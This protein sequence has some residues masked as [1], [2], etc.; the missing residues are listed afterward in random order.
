MIAP[1]PRPVIQTGTPLDAWIGGMPENSLVQVRGPVAVGKSTFLLALAMGLHTTNPELNVLT[2]VQPQDTHLVGPRSW[3]LQAT[4]V[5]DVAKAL[6]A[7]PN[8]DVVLIDEATSYSSKS[9][10][11]AATSKMWTHLIPRERQRRKLTV[12]AGTVRRLASTSSISATRFVGKAADFAADLIIDLA[13][14]A[15]THSHPGMVVEASIHKSRTSSP[16]QLGKRLLWLRPK[17]TPP[18]TLA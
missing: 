16:E 5:E 1:S 9:H 14:V 18:M 13:P 15:R 2:V 6:A 3:I 10:E 4:S 12:M 8:A 7:Q 11:P 17:N